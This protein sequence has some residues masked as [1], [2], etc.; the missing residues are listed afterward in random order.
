VNALGDQIIDSP[1]LGP[2]L[3]SDEHQECDAILQLSQAFAPL[4]DMHDTPKNSHKVHSRFSV[5]PY[6]M[7]GLIGDVLRGC[8]I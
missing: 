7:W 4:F 3:I 6:L 8:T 2:I 5:V 1:R